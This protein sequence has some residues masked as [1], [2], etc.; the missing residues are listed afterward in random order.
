ME[1]RQ[2]A[3]ETI[4]VVQSEHLFELLDVRADVIVRQHDAF[5]LAGAAAGENHGGQIVQAGFSLRAQRSL[6]ESTEWA[7]PYPRERAAY[8]L[9]Y[10]RNHKY[11][12]P[13]GRLDN[14]QG[15]RQ[16]VCSCPPLSGY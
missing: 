10:L 13:V 3:Q 16:F 9:P 12:P 8:P 14:V 1:E 7:H 5:W 4:M 2:D 15:D 6:Q 11:W